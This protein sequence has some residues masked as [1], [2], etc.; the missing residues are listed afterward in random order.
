[1]F[2]SFEKRRFEVLFEQGWLENFYIIIYTTMTPEET[3]LKLLKD[4]NWPVVCNCWVNVKIYRDLERKCLYT[5]GTVID[6]ENHQ[7]KTFTFRYNNLKVE[8]IMKEMKK[9]F[10]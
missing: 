4:W 10:C 8:D 3:K 9:Q 1:M 5:I 2:V 6:W 7:T